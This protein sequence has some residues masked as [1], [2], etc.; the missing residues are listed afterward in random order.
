M[1][2]SIFAPALVLIT[3]FAPS[4]TALKAS[5]SSPCAAQCGN[6]LGSTSGSDIVCANSD[7]KSA[8]A[9]IVFSTCVSCQLASQ[10]VD[11]VTKQSDLHWAICK[12]LCKI[13]RQS[14]NKLLTFQ[15]TIDN[16]RYAVSWCLFGYPDNKNVAGTPCTTRYVIPQ[17][18][19]IDIM[20]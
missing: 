2:P 17:G 8:A 9:G 10:Y 12:Y 4:A 16:L 20:L 11:P 5:T 3:S 7:Y 19:S 15:S 13:H 1:R 14:K 18:P 6:E